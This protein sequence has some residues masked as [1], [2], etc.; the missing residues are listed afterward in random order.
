MNKYRLEKEETV[1]VLAIDNTL[2]RQKQIEKLK[3]VRTMPNAGKDKI[4]YIFKKNLKQQLLLKNDNIQ[5][6]YNICDRY[7]RVA[8]RMPP[9][10]VWLPSR[11]VPALERETCWLWL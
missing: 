10:S 7:G 8:T 1:E 6:K 9:T 11:S 2:V 5:N 4:K 3:T